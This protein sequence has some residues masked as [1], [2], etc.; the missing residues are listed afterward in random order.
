MLLVF[1]WSGEIAV[2]VIEGQVTKTSE[3]AWVGTRA[4]TT[5]LPLIVGLELHFPEV[6]KSRV[7][8]GNSLSL[9]NG[10]PNLE[11]I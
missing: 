1:F 9:K 3:G 10:P 11:A 2:W 8:Q 7:L 4:A 5:Q 6:W